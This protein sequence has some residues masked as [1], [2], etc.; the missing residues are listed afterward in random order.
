M[1]LCDHTAVSGDYESL[2][3]G[4]LQGLSA[5]DSKKSY[6]SGRYLFHVMVSGGIVYMCVTEATFEKVVAFSCLQELQRQLLAMRLEDRAAIAGPYALRGDFSGVLEKEMQKYSSGDQI[7]R[8]QVRGRWE[9]RGWER[10]GGEGWERRGGERRG[11]E[12][13]GGEGWDGMGW[14]GWDGKGR[15]GEGSCDGLCLDCMCVHKLANALRADRAHF[16]IATLAMFTCKVAELYCTL[17]IC[18]FVC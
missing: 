15:G 12:G 9:G 14:E 6:L 5:R 2:V 10:R 17:F 8:M 4:V 11:G 13:R 1:I 7:T 18:S 16:F 3:Q